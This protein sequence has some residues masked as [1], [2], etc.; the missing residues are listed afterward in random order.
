M[1]SALTL[2]N[3]VGAHRAV[4]YC[5]PMVFGRR[6]DRE[7]PKH[8]RK[9]SKPTKGSGRD[10]FQHLRDERAQAEAGDPWFLADDDG[11]ELEIE[12]N[13]S[14]NLKAEDFTAPD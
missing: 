5:A 14:S 10:P 11:P 4:G 1:K 2:G 9:P 6:K 8:M 3:G 13:R 12:T 7:A